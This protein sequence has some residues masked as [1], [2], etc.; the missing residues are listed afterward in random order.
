[1][2]RS[3]ADLCL[4]PQGTVRFEVKPDRRQCPDR[5]RAAR[6]GRRKGDVNA[7]NGFATEVKQPDAVAPLAHA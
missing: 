3:L 4:V 6:G 7:T 1:M 5:R 2:V